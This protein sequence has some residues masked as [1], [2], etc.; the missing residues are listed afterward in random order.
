MR[1]VIRSPVGL[2]VSCPHHHFPEHIRPVLR[3]SREKLFN[4]SKGKHII[5]FMAWRNKATQA[6]LLEK[7][8]R[9]ISRELET[10]PKAV[11]V[12]PVCR[13]WVRGSVPA[14]PLTTWAHKL[15]PGGQWRNKV[16]VTECTETTHT[17]TH[18]QERRKLGTYD[19]VNCFLWKGWLNYRVFFF[20]SDLFSSTLVLRFRDIQRPSFALRNRTWPSIRSC[21]EG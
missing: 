7:S 5:N 11:N 18:T 2:Q 9:W 17:H 3:R 16:K 15:R 21:H 8:E 4:V 20:N 13:W 6:G 19:F 1:E 10:G 14:A 12:G